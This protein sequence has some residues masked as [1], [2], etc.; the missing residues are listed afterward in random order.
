ME[1]EFSLN[2]QVNV[3]LMTCNLDKTISNLDRHLQKKLSMHLRYSRLLLFSV[4]WL[5]LCAMQVRADLVDVML[6][7][8]I[9]ETSAGNGTFEL[10]ATANP[11]TNAGLASYQIPLTGGI[12]SADH[13]SPNGGGIHPT[14]GFGRIGF[15]LLRSSEIDDGA[16]FFRASQDTV[17]SAGMILYDMG[18][19][20]GNINSA[21]PAPSSLF[22]STQADY[23]APLQL[24][25]GFW[26]GI[27]PSFATDKIIA[28]N[29]FDPA[30]DRKTFAAEFGTQVD[31]SAIPEP[32]AATLSLCALGALGLFKI[33][34][35][36]RSRL[37]L[38]MSISS[39]ALDHHGS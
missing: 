19:N 3:H 27:H 2:P 36:L 24:A 18:I 38:G 35:I 34:R 25:H 1:L 30:R 4:L 7:L 5:S 29:V 15:G 20:G 26:S 28:G 22:L 10:L 39:S 33:A 32:S 17:D 31:F 16:A 14:A 23:D 37:G 11:A 6:T 12:A 21:D 9:I 13:T 8:K